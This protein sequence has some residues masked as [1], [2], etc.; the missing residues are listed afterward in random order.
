MNI[1]L[2]KKNKI[3][4]LFKNKGDQIKHHFSKN[5]LFVNENT[6]IKLVKIDPSCQQHYQHIYRQFYM[7][8]E[9]IVLNLEFL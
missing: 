6:K 1:N 3:P 4:M 7:S 2:S 5:L 8:S 9:G